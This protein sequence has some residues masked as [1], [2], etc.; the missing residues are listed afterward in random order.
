MLVDIENMITECRKVRSTTD[1]CVIVS[2]DG[3]VQLLREAFY[4]QNKKIDF[5]EEPDEL[6]IYDGVPVKLRVQAHPGIAT[7]ARTDDLPPRT[8]CDKTAV[9]AMAYAMSWVQA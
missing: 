5:T 6:F 7:L 2:A 4:S 3:A 9:I 8:C 1:L